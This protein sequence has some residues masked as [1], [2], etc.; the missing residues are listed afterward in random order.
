MRGQEMKF[1]IAFSGGGFRATFYSLGVY[2]RLIELNLHGNISHID[3]VSGGS[4]TAAAI[5]CALADN[6][7][8]SVDDFDERVTKPLIELGQCQFRRKI[9]RKVLYPSLPRS[10]FSKVFPLL[11]DSLI[12]KNRK[13]VEL[14]TNPIWSCHATCLNTGKRFRFKQS[15]VGGNTIGVTKDINDIKV[16]FA[17]AS[18]ASF[19][20]MFAPL[21]LK[22][23]NR[24]FYTKW[25]SENPVLNQKQLPEI[26]YLSDGGVYDNLGSE[27][28]IQHKDPFIIC[29]ASAFLEKWNSAK[30][31]NWFSMNNRPLDTGLEQVVLL[32][33]RLLY[34]ASKEAYGVQLLL[35]DPVQKFISD[36][37]V[38][39]RLS[40]Q[41]F[42]LPDYENISTENQRLISNLRTD[43]DGFHN[44]EIECLMWSGAMKIDIL[45]KRYFQNLISVKKVKDTP[46]PPRYSEIKLKKIL[47]LGAKRKILSNL[48]KSFK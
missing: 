18:S 43:L 1:R 37:E 47:T 19:P 23:G 17:V 35:R 11:L 13:L 46:P 45:V 3:S 27:S 2:R 20:M 14:P 40:D 44:A 15:E 6:H 21:K 34:Y 31:P 36:P 41:T 16:S 12:F 7:F 28:L 39:G 5:M 48:H 22:T 32:R 10:R 25:W 9:F 33:R 42:D 24:K 29:D 30:K 8:L 38:F 26:L 4:F